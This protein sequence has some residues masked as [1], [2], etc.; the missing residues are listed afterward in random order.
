[1]SFPFNMFNPIDSINSW[2][3]ISIPS[4]SMFNTINPTNSWNP[5]SIPSF[6]MFNTINPTNSW[7]PTS[8]P[9]FNMFDTNNNIFANLQNLC[10]KNEIYGINSNGILQSIKDAGYDKNKGLKLAK[11]AQKNAVGFK[12]KC[13]TYV[14]KAIEESGLGKYEYGHAYEC[15]NILKKN[16][17]FK[18]IST[19]GL[20]LSKLP[21]GC[22]LVYGKKVAKYSPQYGHVEIT[23]G[24]GKAASDGITNNIRQGARVFVPVSKNYIA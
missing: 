16:K 6:S 11:I 7:S 8:F 21:A 22:V 12:H 1:M 15:A 13:A 5:I 3:P 10:S 4:F 14:K 19:K 2:N 17:N 23:L 18:E 20:D 24:N 9:L